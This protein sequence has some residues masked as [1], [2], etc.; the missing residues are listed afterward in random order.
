MITEHDDD[1]PA[2]EPFEEERPAYRDAEPDGLLLDIE[3]YEGPIDILLT[4]AREQKVDLTRI[5]I[6]ALAD[7]Y[8]EYVSRARRLRLELA[9]D[10]LVMAAWLAYLKSR[11]LLP[12]P[13]GDDEPSGAEMAAML[14][15]QL[16]RLEAMKAAGVKLLDRPRMGRDF[17]PR[18]AAEV[19]EDSKRSLFDLSLYDILRAYADQHGRR[20]AST[21]HIAPT[22][23][24]SIDEAINRLRGLIGEVADWATL[25]SFLPDG[26]RDDL[27]IRSAIASTF[28][29]SL[30]LAKLGQIQIRQREA[31][32]TLYIR[33]QQAGQ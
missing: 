15:F 10:Y 23:L 30:E 25:S 24:Y 19:L 28:V 26:I 29:A 17:L 9:A 32:S 27:L 12:A 1:D 16:Q 2:E 21:L 13:P 3:G 7:Q 18:G 6:L 4:L 11:L 5:S 33:K 22:G 31:F 20:E 8:L 14:A